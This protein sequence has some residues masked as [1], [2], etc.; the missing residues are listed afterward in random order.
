MAD[1]DVLV[2]ERHRRV[3]QAEGLEEA[4][5]DEGDVFGA[6]RRGERLA[7]Q[8]RS[9]VAVPGSTDRLE[10]HVPRLAQQLVERRVDAIAAC[11]DVGG[12]PLHQLGVGR[13]EG[14]PGLVRGEVA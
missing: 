2:L 8:R 10:L 14:Q 4:F 5:G 11:L 13:V 1:R 7:Q 12:R 6:G 3:V 9:D